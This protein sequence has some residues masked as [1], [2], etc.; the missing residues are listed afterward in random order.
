MASPFFIVR[1]R[2]A[3]AD[4]SVTP[5]TMY[6]R[7]RFDFTPPPMCQSWVRLWPQTPHDRPSQTPFSSAHAATPARIAAIEQRMRES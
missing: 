7:A 6:E 1:H 3:R 2:P 5:N 4:E